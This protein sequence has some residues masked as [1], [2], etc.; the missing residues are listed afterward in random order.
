MITLGASSLPP[1]L[2]P[3]PILPCTDLQV[4]HFT[5]LH[6]NEFCLTMFRTPLS[7]TALQTKQ[8]VQNREY[9]WM[10][11]WSQIQNP[12]KAW[13]LSFFLSSILICCRLPFPHSRCV[14]LW[15][16]NTVTSPPGNDGARW[17][18]RDRQSDGQR[19]KNIGEKKPLMAAYGP[20]LYRFIICGVVRDISQLCLPWTAPWVLGGIAEDC[21]CDYLFTNPPPLA[22]WTPPPSKKKE[23][24]IHPIFF[25]IRPVTLLIT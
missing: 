6:M 8:H 19:A 12:S 18:Q 21:R 2:L 24:K 5:P 13:L 4:G 23:K 1:D 17:R 7:S 11:G 20:P 15:I 9:M 25:S 3:P 10:D 14:L 16:I 22:T